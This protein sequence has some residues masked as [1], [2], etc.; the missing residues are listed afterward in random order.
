MENAYLTVTV[1][2]AYLE[3]ELATIVLDV[4]LLSVKMIR[5]I[6]TLIPTVIA[7]YL[8]YTTTNA[9]MNA[10]MKLVTSTTEHVI[11]ILDVMNV[12]LVY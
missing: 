7:L 3:T 6:V 2:L 8:N 5:E 1:Y 12:I 4:G 10:T 11:L 9:T